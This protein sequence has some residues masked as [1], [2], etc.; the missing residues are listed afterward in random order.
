MRL[1]A[2]C[3]KLKERVE[4]VWTGMGEEIARSHVQPCDDHR[5]ACGG[6]GK[7]DRRCGNSPV[8]RDE[9]GKDSRGVE[10]RLLERDGLLEEEN[11]RARVR[12][13]GGQ[14]PCAA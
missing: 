3:L 4:R 14:G 10:Q 7:I 2:G 5:T 8:G 13:T 12:Q 9:R 11:R 6:D 1:Q